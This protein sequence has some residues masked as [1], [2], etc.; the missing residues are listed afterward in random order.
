[1]KTASYFHGGSTVSVLLVL[2]L[3]AALSNGAITTNSTSAIFMSPQQSATSKLTKD[4][5]PVPVKD[6]R[7]WQFFPSGHD[8]APSE[9]LDAGSY[10][11]T[12]ETAGGAVIV[13]VFIPRRD[14]PNIVAKRAALARQSEKKIEETLGIA[15]STARREIQIELRP[16]YYE[17]QT[18]ELTV[19]TKLERRHTCAW[20]INGNFVAEEPKRNALTYTFREAGEYVVT[21]IETEKKNGKTAAVAS[22]TAYTR[23]VPAPGV[24]TEV[25]I[26]TE[27]E[28]TPPRGYEKHVWCIDGV[29]VSSAPVLKHAFQV[30]GSHTVECLASAPSQGPAQGFLRLRYYTTV[31][32]K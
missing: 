14:M 10:D 20:F 28:F 1:M 15:I 30:P 2:C 9:I 29:V 24:P 5:V 22:A 26:N 32:S 13:P 23:V 18:L 17:G 7:G 3:S 11:V 12:V 19:A 31:N 16:V 6:I 8:F 21:Y 25:T 4:G 27:T